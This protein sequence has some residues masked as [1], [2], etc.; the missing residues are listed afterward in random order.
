MNPAES[1]PRNSRGLGRFGPNTDRANRHPWRF[2]RTRRRTNSTSPPQ[3]DRPKQF[4]ELMGADAARTHE[5]E[6][7]LSLSFSFVGDSET[8]SGTRWLRRQAGAG[9][10]HRALP[11]S[12]GRLVRRR[13]PRDLRASN[14]PGD[15]ES[16]SSRVF[17]AKSWA[18]S[19]KRERTASARASTRGNALRESGEK[20]TGEPGRVSS[21]RA[22]PRGY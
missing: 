20:T 19:R 1:R 10:Q 3:A 4:L 22:Y 15:H 7:S 11:L 5:Y 14:A 12:D 8:L 2:A 21:T 17:A 6:L 9:S 13:R 18:V 16:G